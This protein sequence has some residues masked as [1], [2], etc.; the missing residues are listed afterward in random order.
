[1]GYVNRI[2]SS[3]GI[4]SYTSV[5]SD[6]NFRNS[7]WSFYYSCR[8]NR[9]GELMIKDLKKMYEDLGFPTKEEAMKF[10]RALKADM[11]SKLKESKNEQ[12]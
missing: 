6:I 12:N 2:S 11:L 1:M 3:N 10:L 7:Y 9:I 4:I 8:L 5:S